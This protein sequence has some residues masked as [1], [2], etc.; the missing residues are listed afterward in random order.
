MC[1]VEHT[2]Q[3]VDERQPR[4]DE[5]VE[6]AQAEAGDQKQNDSAHGVWHLLGMDA[7]QLLH[8]VGVGEQRRAG[9][10]CTVRPASMTTTSSASRSITWRFCSTSR[11]GTVCAAAASAS[12][13]SV[14]DLRREAL[15]RLVDE[16]DPV[17]V[18]QARASD[19]ICCCPPDRVPARWSAR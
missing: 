4:R 13:T 2:H 6:R 8:P 9:P 3:A 5:E 16:Q 14:D 18:E 1:E 11:I 19:S 10:E 17:V 12:A 15:R 7:Q